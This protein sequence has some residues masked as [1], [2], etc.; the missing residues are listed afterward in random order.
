MYHYRLFGRRI[1]SEIA[2]GD[3]ASRR[4]G[5]P[6]LVVGRPAELDADADLSWY[7]TIRDSRRT[8]NISFARGQHSFL[9][10]F[11]GAMDFVISSDGRNIV[12]VARKRIPDELVRT[13]CLSQVLPLALSLRGVPTLHASAVAIRGRAVAF[14]GDDGQG[15]STLAAAFARAGDPVLTDDALALTVRRGRLVAIPSFPEIGIFRDVASRFFRTP[16]SPLHRQKA[17]IPLRGIFCRTALPL[18]VIYKLSPREGGSRDSC[19][20]RRLRGRKAWFTLL[21]HAFRLDLGSQDKLKEEA[22]FFSRVAARVPVKTLRLA[23]GLKRLPAILRQVRD[24][25]IASLLA[26]P[27]ADH[28]AA[29]ARE[30]ARISSPTSTR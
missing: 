12:P 9:V 7:H 11:H 26:D 4:L 29:D 30:P 17:R 18:G 13:L 23:R 27:E 20:I 8:R 16:S 28:V 21:R 10:R 25:A 5:P 1:A 14:L 24:D 15:K 2:L 3:F 6:D 22:S 19:E